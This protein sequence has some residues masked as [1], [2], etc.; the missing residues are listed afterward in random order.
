MHDGMLTVKVLVQAVI[1][2]FMLICIVLNKIT[3]TLPKSK[4]EMALWFAAVTT[5]CRVLGSLP[6]LSETL[7]SSSYCSN[8]A[9]L[10][11]SDF[12][13]PCPTAASVFQPCPAML[14]S[15][16]SVKSGFLKGSFLLFLNLWLLHFSIW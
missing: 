5:V 9:L 14:S 8:W 11:P 1:C 13:Q 7:L 4:C 16:A 12:C 6:C 10:Q 2:L 3:I 15:H